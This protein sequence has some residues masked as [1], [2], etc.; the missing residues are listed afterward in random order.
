[1]ASPQNRYTSFE[2]YHLVGRNCPTD[3]DTNYST[4]LKV[5]DSG[6]ISHPPHSR[7]CNQ[8]LSF[9]W[10]ES[11]FNEKL[12]VPDITCFCDIPFEA[13]HIHVK[14]YGMFGLSFPRDYLVKYGARPVIYVP[15]QPSKPMRGWGTIFCEA[16]DLEQ[17]WRGVREQ[18]PTT[19][20]SNTRSLGEKPSS[21]E[22]ALI[23]MEGAFTKDFLAFI[24]PFNSELDD[25]DSNN[26]Y[27]EREWR[28]LCNLP[29]QPQNVASVVV[30]NDYFD[31][32]AND[33]PAFVGR[34]KVA[35]E[36]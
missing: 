26:Y 35:P 33:R 8:R 10:D 34:I 1:M 21:P 22:S 16:F 31:R 4:L 18:H 15:M 12:I 14:K 11:I 32:L 28:K 19:N 20:E 5:L 3:H 2:L 29:F 23:A 17:I 24:K 9:N 36:Y 30:Q 13:L 25:D 7:Y 27:M 6:Q